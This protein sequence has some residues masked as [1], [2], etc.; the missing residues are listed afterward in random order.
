MLITFHCL[1]NYHLLLFISIQTDTA[2]VLTFLSPCSFIKAQIWG[3]KLINHLWS[4]HRRAH[5]NYFIFNKTNR[6]CTQIKNNKK[7]LNFTK[8]GLNLLLTCKKQSDCLKPIYQTSDQGGRPAYQTS[9]RNTIARHKDSS[10]FQHIWL[11]L[12]IAL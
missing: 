2:N 10:K 6:K 3:H 8:K 4:F 12:R 1:I 9:T 7:K 11:L 5:M